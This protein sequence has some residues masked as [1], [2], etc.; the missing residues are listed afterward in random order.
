M[1]IATLHYVPL[2]MTPV[3]TE[4][5]LLATN[6][7]DWFSMGELKEITKNQLDQDG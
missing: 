1:W 4:L 2:A 3:Y 6:F 5:L 7:L